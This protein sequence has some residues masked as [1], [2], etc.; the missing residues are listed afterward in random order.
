MDRNGCNFKP[1]YILEVSNEEIYNTYV[2]DWYVYKV[3][4]LYAASLSWCSDFS[5][6]PVSNFS[7]Y[8]DHMNAI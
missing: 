1:Y 5:Q 6:L 3:A 7:I 4:E 8:S 2:H